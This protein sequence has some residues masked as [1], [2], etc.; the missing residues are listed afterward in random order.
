MKRI[1]RR[2]GEENTVFLHL[3]VQKNRQNIFDCFWYLL[4][5]G[6]NYIKLSYF[7][8]SIRGSPS[9][10]EIHTFF[11]PFLLGRFIVVTVKERKPMYLV[12]KSQIESII[13]WNVTW[14][15]V[16]GLFFLGDCDSRVK[17]V[18]RIIN[19]N[20]NAR[21][22]NCYF[23]DAYGPKFSFVFRYDWQIKFLCPVRLLSVRLARVC[24]VC[25]ITV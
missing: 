1:I 25:L 4:F 7:Q 8:F 18:A 2:N 10:Q 20:E 14:A 19:S 11:T 17:H 21:W 5:D 23:N 24:S 22:W 3:Y 9:T 6:K 13:S 12:P 15:I 16:R